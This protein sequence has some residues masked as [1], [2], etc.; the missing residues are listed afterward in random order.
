MQMYIHKRVIAL[1]I[2]EKTYSGKPQ[3]NGWFVW[4][5]DVEEA[6]I[7]GKEMWT[8]AHNCDNSYSGGIILEENLVQISLII[9]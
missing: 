5:S 2:Q 4:C 6:V 1:F 9:T 3:I 8:C 7:R